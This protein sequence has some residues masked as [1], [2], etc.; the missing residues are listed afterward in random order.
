MLCNIHSIVFMIL[1]CTYNHYVVIFWWFY[2]YFGLF[3]WRMFSYSLELLICL[4][5]SRK[6]WDERC[7]PSP[8][9][10]GWGWAPGLV[11]SRPALYA[12]SH[13]LGLVLC[14]LKL[15]FTPW[16][17]YHECADLVWKATSLLFSMHPSV[18]FSWEVLTLCIHDLQTSM[19]PWTAWEDC[20]WWMGE[21]N[22]QHL[23][24]WVALAASNN[25]S[26]Q[27]W[28]L[29]ETPLSIMGVALVCFSVSG[30]KHSNQK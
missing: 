11:H 13:I 18:G 6:H 25:H 23:S 26:R 7:V 8:L 28:L 22:T 16:P 5:P 10:Q 19:M 1:C 2:F 3:C 24:I 4:P 9:T 15:S 27:R 17:H 12:L 14:N 30:I 29:S 20:G 21:Q